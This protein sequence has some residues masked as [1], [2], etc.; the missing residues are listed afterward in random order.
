MFFLIIENFPFMI[1]FIFQINIQKYEIINNYVVV[2]APL[3]QMQKL[4]YILIQEWKYFFYF[5]TNINLFYF[6]KSK[7]IYNII[8]NLYEILKYII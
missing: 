2:K 4:F 5:N 6:F 7:Y 8:Y 3:L 1:H